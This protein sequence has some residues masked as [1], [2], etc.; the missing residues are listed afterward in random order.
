M[1]S[2]VAQKLPCEGHDFG[3]FR[4]ATIVLMTQTAT[5]GS[6][7]MVEEGPNY[8]GWRALVDDRGL[9][10]RSR[11]KSDIIS[12]TTGTDDEDED[13][14]EERKNEE[15][16]KQQKLQLFQ[17]LNHSFVQAEPTPLR[18]RRVSF[19]RELL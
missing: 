15:S 17:H 18:V 13:G 4:D 1:V 14:V 16:M 7:W 9:Q 3:T 8:L 19:G 5:E 6:I 2:G 10:L 11:R 12:G